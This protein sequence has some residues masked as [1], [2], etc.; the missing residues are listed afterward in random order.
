M[1]DANTLA[2]SFA[3]AGQF[4]RLIAAIVFTTFAWIA[5]L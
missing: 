1:A 4:D 2:P 5:F 3:G